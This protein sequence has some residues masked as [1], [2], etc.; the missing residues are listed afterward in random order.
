[1]DITTQAAINI[2]S[3]TTMDLTAATTITSTVGG[4]SITI[5]TAQIDV[6]SA[7]VNI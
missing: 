3:D 4:S 1:M 6:T 2:N 7:L 5:A